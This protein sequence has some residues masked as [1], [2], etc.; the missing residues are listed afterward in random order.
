VERAIVTVRDGL[1][2]RNAV[3]DFDVPTDLPVERLVELFQV[4]FGAADRPAGGQIV[5]RVALRLIRPTEPAVELHANQSLADVDAWDGSVLELVGIRE[6]RE[7][8]RIGPVQEWKSLL[9]NLADVDELARVV[10]DEQ[11]AARSGDQGYVRK[12]VD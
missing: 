5:T 11:T 9:D 4:A 6:E 8:R 1:S 2:G 10:V 12:R 7:G 3:A